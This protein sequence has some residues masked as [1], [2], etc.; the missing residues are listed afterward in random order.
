MHSGRRRKPAAPRSSM[1]PISVIA[2]SLTLVGAMGVTL[3][4]I[5]KAHGAMK[6]VK[7]LEQELGDLEVVLSTIQSFLQQPRP[8]QEPHSFRPQLLQTSMKLKSV[9]TEMNDLLKNRW[10]T[11]E[12]KVKRL[13][14]I[15]D[16]GR[17][18]QLRNVV[19]TQKA[20]L[21]V[22]VGVTIGLDCSQFS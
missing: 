22:M 13:R 5:R 6:D 10:L 20:N 14:W 4:T 12:D 2:S 17:L 8:A 15:I 11:R 9:L 19:L 18:E 7:I 16:Q 21:S 3:N 1:D